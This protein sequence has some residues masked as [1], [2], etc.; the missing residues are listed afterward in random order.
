MPNHSPVDPGA[1]L[2]GSHRPEF[3]PRVRLRLPHRS[4]A[5]ALRSLLARHGVDPNDLQLTSLLRFDPRERMVICATV[6]GMQPDEVVGV[7]VI[8]FRGDGTPGT[9]IADPGVEE[10]LR[11]ALCELVRR[12]ARRAA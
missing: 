8:D 4:D 5:A 1:L 2:V 12:R 6:A 9:L 3:G 11:E 10:L 7:G